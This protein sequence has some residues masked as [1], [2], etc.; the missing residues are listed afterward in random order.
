VAADGFDERFRVPYGE[1]TDLAWRCIEGGARTRFVPE[2]VVEHEVRPSSL[3]AHLRDVRRRE[4]M[5]LT[6]A[7]HPGFRHLLP[8]RGYLR[9]AHVPL[10]AMA[11]S[12]A[13]AVTVRPAAI[14]LALTVGTGGWYAWTVRRLRPR[15]TRKVDWLPTVALAAVAD[16]YE[17]G[18]L[19]R[20]SV[21]YRCLVL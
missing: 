2:A 14:G 21:R 20:A 7:K 12:T 17:V 6:I 3:G 4:G 11:A 9:P 5:V 8:H 10:L 15:P 13:V 16:G 19:A 18:V 1:D